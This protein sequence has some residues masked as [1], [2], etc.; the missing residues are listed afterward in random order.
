M[1]QLFLVAL[2]GGIGA[3]LRHLSGLAA[4]RLLGAGFPYGTMFVNVVGSFVMG[5]FIELL[6]RRFGGSAELRLFVATGV[7]GGFTTFSSFSLDTAFLYERGDVALAA[8]YVIGSVVIG[9]AALFAGLALVR[10][11]A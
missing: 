10:A 2:G 11:L 8:I 3:A 7:L 9:I 6:S 1:Y 5:V 4:M